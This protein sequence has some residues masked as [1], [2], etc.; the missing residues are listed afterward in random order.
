MLLKNFHNSSITKK[1]SKIVQIM[2]KKC[3]IPVKDTFSA[4]LTDTVPKDTLSKHEQLEALHMLNV[5]N[6]I[7]PYL[8]DKVKVKILS[9]TYKV[10]GCHSSWSTRH[11]LRLFETQLEHSNQK[12]IH[13]EAE[14]IMLALTSY[15][16]TAGKGHVD[17]II[18]ASTLLKYV[19]KKVKDAF[20]C[21][22]LTYLPPVFAS[23]IGYLGSDSTNSKPVVDILKELI[24]FHIHQCLFSIPTS[25]AGTYEMESLPEAAA[26]ASICSASVKLLNDCIFPTEHMLEVMSLLFLRLELRDELRI[27]T[28]SLSRKKNFI[29]WV[30]SV[31]RVLQAKGLLPH[32]TQAPPTPPIDDWLRNDGRVQ[33]WILN[34]LDG[35]PY[36]MDM[37]HETA[38][39]MWTELHSLFSGR[40]SLQ[41]LYDILTD[42]FSLDAGGA[43]DM[44][45]FVAR[46]KT[47]AEAWIQ[48]QPFTNDPLAQ[49]AQKEAACTA[50]LM[51]RLPPHLQS[52][53]AQVLASSTTPSFSDVCS[54]ILRVPPPPDTTAPSALLQQAPPLLPFPPPPSTR[55][56]GGGGVVQAL[57]AVVVVAGVGRSVPS[58]A[59][60]V[61]SRQPVTRKL[62]I[63]LAR[64]LLLLPMLVLLILKVS[65]FIS[66][67]SRACS[68]PHLPPLPPSPTQYLNSPYPPSLTVANG[69]TVPV[70][71]SADLPLT[72]SISL[73]SALHVPS[74]PFNLLS[75]GRLTTDL[76]CSVIFTSS[77]FVIQDRRTQTTIG[78]GRLRNGLYLLDDSPTILSF[79]SSTDWHRRLGHAPLPV[80]WRSFPDVSLTPFQCDSCILGK[81][82]RSS[83]SSHCTRSAAPFDLV[84]SDIWGP[85]KIS[86]ISGFRY[87]I[88]FID[89]HSRTTWTILRDRSELPRVFRAFVLETRTQF[90]K[91]IKSYALTMLV[92]T[93]VTNLL[94]Y[95]PSLGFSI[96]LPALTRRNKMVLPNARIATYLMLPVSSCFKC[97]SLNRIG[98]LRSRPPAFSSTVSLPLFSTTLLR[99]ASSFPPLQHFLSHLVCLV[100][101]VMSTGYICYSPATRKISVSVDVTFRENQPFFSAPLPDHSP[102]T[103]PSIPRPVIPATPPLP[104]IPSPPPAV[105]SKPPV[106]RV[107]TRRST[108]S[109]APLPSV[110]TM[111]TPHPTDQ[112]SPSTAHPLAN[113]VSLHRLSPHL[114][115][116]A[117]SLSSVA[118]PNFVQEALQHPGWRA[119]MEEE[120]SALWS[121]QTWLSQFALNVNEGKHDMKHVS[122]NCKKC[123][124]AS[125]IAIGP[126]K[127]LALF[128]IAIDMQETSCS[129]S[130]II[131]ILKKYVVGASLQYFINNIVPLIN[132][133]KDACKKVKKDTVRKSLQ[134]YFHDLWDLLP[135]FCRYPIDLPENFESLSMLLMVVLKDETSLHE[136]IALGL[137]MLVYSN[138]EDNR[139][140]VLDPQNFDMEFINFGYSKRTVSKNMKALSSRSMDFF[141]ILKDI[142]LESAEKRGCIKSIR[143]GGTCTELVVG[144]HGCA[145]WLAIRVT[146][147]MK[148]IKTILSLRKDK[149]IGS[150][151]YIDAKKVSE[152]PQIFGFHCLNVRPLLHFSR[153]SASANPA[154]SF[155]YSFVFLRLLLYDRE[156]F[157]LHLLLLLLLLCAKLSVLSLSCSRADAALPL[158]LLALFCLC[159]FSVA[160]SAFGLGFLLLLSFSCVAAATA[161]LPLLLVAAPE[162]PPPCCYDQAIASSFCSTPVPYWSSSIQYFQ[163]SS[164]PLPY[165]SS[166]IQYFQFNTTVAYLS[167]SFQFSTLNSVLLR[168]RTGQVQFSTFNLLLLQLRTGQVHFSS[169]LPFQYYSSFVLREVADSRT[170][171]ASFD[172]LRLPATSVCSAACSSASASSSS[173]WF[174]PQ[175]SYSHFSPCTVGPTSPY[176]SHSVRRLSAVRYLSTVRCDLLLFSLRA[177]N[178][179]CEL[180]AR[181]LFTVV[182]FSLLRTTPVRRGPVLPTVL[183]QPA[184]GSSYPLRAIL[185]RRAL[186]SAAFLSLKSYSRPPTRRG[187]FQLAAI[188]LLSY[189]RALLVLHALLSAAFLSLESY[190]RPLTRRGLVQLA[191]ICFSILL[192][193]L[194]SCGLFCSDHCCA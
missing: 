28:I 129:N 67:I 159:G 130:W 59:K 186:L 49:R 154:A 56:G 33:T 93:L 83:F 153:T 124:G 55:G 150:T 37:Y 188:C 9:D 3:I 125:I 43:S 177:V 189:S 118:I 175:A 76:D 71:G 91:T 152:I 66:S 5:L 42:L 26:I 127:L 16:S 7:L 113:S 72:S 40:D 155:S 151:G 163:F 96:K 88:T 47:L 141:Q 142:F 117:T 85:F 64:R 89:D 109:V 181:V 18:S 90:H 15:I 94:L 36:Q 97:M 100:A 70:S 180:P 35:E 135:A 6:V 13:S 81:Q 191:V 63:L 2:H 14:N 169:V 46:A 138:R 101:Y 126:E 108:P 77:S 143:V 121:N 110:S 52:I 136:V 34:S 69:A 144:I 192:P 162:L 78:K 106:I 134:S 171:S 173:P 164:T 161:R 114:R 50:I 99:S 104:V 123:I 58:V 74:S 38:K 182:V 172:L 128:P 119:A 133:I 112:V 12:V 176:S 137:Q 185:V 174:P 111:D 107:Y 178:I 157:L 4:E 165:W 68:I 167:S 51:A 146:S 149:T 187:L 21:M 116:L 75:V 10:L 45:S 86:S 73:R 79:I 103:P 25:Q 8:S 156:E 115:T 140:H 57:A 54:M 20:P 29:P 19:L 145:S 92:S 22:W 139:H 44:S 168:S 170:L 84:H 105:P 1:A 53:R 60:T 24:S 132:S 82:P 166:S 102:P 95:V 179:R 48:H 23:L 122:F 39:D 41:H 65:V 80:L 30:H 87:F 158:S 190:S 61:I 11:I 160:A 62:A 183:A 32:L 31:R 193:S 148:K 194:S 17:T 184:A 131:P 120:M 98:I 27:T 147:V